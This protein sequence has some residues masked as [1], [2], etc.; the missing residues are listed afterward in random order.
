MSSTPPILTSCF[1]VAFKLQIFYLQIFFSPL[2]Q[3]RRN[4]WVAR[5][6]LWPSW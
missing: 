4:Y 5:I 3:M 2:I 6:I 1:D